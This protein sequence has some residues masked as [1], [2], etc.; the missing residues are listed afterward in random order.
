MDR[1]TTSSR[2]LRIIVFWVVFC[3]AVVLDQATKAAVR[4]CVPAEGRTLLPGI[5]DLKV[6]HNTGAAFSLGE[7]ASPLFV[8]IAAAVVVAALLV[9]WRQD[10][11]PLPLVV[12]I[13]CVAGG[14]AGNMIDRI[15]EGSV[16]DF[17][18]TSFMD[19]PVFNVADMLVTVGVFVTFVG[20]LVWDHRREREEEPESVEKGEVD[21]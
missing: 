9:V 3:L 4:V 19:F 12:S 18:A 17:L 5:L 15:L 8:V 11:L 2:G 16:T 10:G 21:A 7:G 1:R 6:V 20:F 14:G 13:G